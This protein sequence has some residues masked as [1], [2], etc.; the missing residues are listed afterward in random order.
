LRQA[1]FE[2]STRWT[3]LVFHCDLRARVFD[4]D[5]FRL[6]TATTSSPSVLLVAGSDSLHHTS[7][8]VTIRAEPLR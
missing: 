1:R 4:R 2:H 7:S 8:G 3:A 6:G 5:I